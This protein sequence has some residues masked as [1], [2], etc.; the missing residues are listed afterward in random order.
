MK[1][2][3][4]SIALMV[5]S[6]S[7][8]TDNCTSTSSFAFLVWNRKLYNP[9]HMGTALDFNMSQFNP[10]H[11]LSHLYYEDLSEY[12]TLYACVSKVFTFHQ[13]FQ[14]Q[15]CV[16]FSCPSCVLHVTPIFSSLWCHCF[17]LLSFC[18][19]ISR[20]HDYQFT[21]FFLLWSLI[22]GLQNLLQRWVA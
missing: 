12:S 18:S 17:S 7:G 6:Y 2:R 21:T 16:Y 5:W 8:E 14:L 10:V 19:N 22:R 13:V 4:F 3:T 9:L 20:L 1:E 11:N 15:F